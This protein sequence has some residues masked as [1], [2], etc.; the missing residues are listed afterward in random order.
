LSKRSQLL[1]RE[2]RWR[3]ANTLA[4]TFIPYPVASWIYESGSLTARLR[5]LYGDTFNL[6]VVDQ[7]WSRLFYGEGLSLAAPRY[8]HALVREVLLCNGERP[9]VAARSIMPSEALQGS[10]SRLARLG[11][12]PLGEILFSY[13]G[14]RRD[15]L[16]YARIGAVD[17]QPDAARFTGGEDAWGRRSLYRVA[18]GHILVCEFFLSELLF[19]L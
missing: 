15:R 12:R 18:G 7:S 5:R 13:R 9:L 17:W 8:R 16:D 11:T 14:L 1:L 3:T 19:P 2:P 4:R 10:G 6:R